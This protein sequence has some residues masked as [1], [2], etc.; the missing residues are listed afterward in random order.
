MFSDSILLNI[1]YFVPPLLVAVIL[2]EIAHGYVAER[3]GDP[4]ARNMNRIN[5]NPIVHIDLFFT[6]ILPL[7]LILSNTGIVFGG[8]KPVPVDPRYFKNPRRGMLWVALAG[9]VTNFLLAILSYVLILALPLVFG[10]LPVSFLEVIGT[11]LLSSIFI[12][13]VLALFNLIPVP[14]LDGGRILVGILPERLAYYVARIE[15]FGLF[16][17]IAL[18]YF[19]IPQMILLPALQFVQGLLL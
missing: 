17:L 13:V 19:E 7:L 18:I 9:P 16:I 4:T 14:P 2:H 1:L 8:A 5:L 15:P 6:I 12:N 11:W 3:L 10:F